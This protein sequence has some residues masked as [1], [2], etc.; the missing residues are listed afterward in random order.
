MKE[1]KLIVDENGCIEVAYNDK[2]GG[3]GISKRALERM[4]ELGSEDAKKYY[5]KLD[6]NLLS[7]YDSFYHDVVRFDPILI[8]VIKELGKRA[9]GGGSRLAVAKV[10][11]DSLIQTECY[12][13]KESVRN[14]MDYTIYGE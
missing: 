5:E 9:N 11:L 6:K 14:A 13:G 12:D 3:F 10:H 8:Q 1:I 2:Y 7:S 4:V